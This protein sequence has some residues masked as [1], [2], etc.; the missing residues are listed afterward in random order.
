MFSQLSANIKRINNI[1]LVPL[2]EPKSGG[3]NKRNSKNR[4]RL[5]TWQNRRDTYLRRSLY[6]RLSEWSENGRKN[7]ISITTIEYKARFDSS[8]GY[9]Y[10]VALNLIKEEYVVGE[11]A[12][13]QRISQ[14]HR[15]TVSRTVIS[16]RHLSHSASAYR[17]VEWC[18]RPTS[19]YN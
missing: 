15:Q 3:K 8:W 1:L 10:D 17:Y 12:E 11:K 4:G 9:Q 2:S 14:S 6:R 16:E 7:C 5:W 18:T 19:S 13:H